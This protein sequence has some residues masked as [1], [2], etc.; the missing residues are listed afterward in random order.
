[1]KLIIYTFCVKSM[2]LF[3]NRGTTIVC[4]HVIFNG[5]LYVID[6]LKT[7]WQ[8]KKIIDSC[9]KISL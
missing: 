3:V 5:F 1:M 9:R 7:A 2:F 4:G 6:I 8:A